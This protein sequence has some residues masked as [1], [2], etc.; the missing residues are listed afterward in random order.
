MAAAAADPALLDGASLPP[1]L[2]IFLAMF[3]AV[4]L[5][6]HLVVFRGWSPEARPEA[7]SCLISLA[8]GTP[9][10]AL[11]SFALLSDPSR[12]FAARNTGAQDAVLEYS[13]AYFLADLVH[14]LVFYPKD[15]LFIG[16]HLATLFVFLTCRY[17]VR[18]GAFAIL[19]LLILAEVTSACQNAWT[20]SGVRRRDSA[21]AAKV[22]DALSAP[23]YSFYSVVR[24]LFGPLFLYKMGVF[25]ASGGAEG[26]IPRWVWVSWLVV[27]SLAIGVSILWVS[28][29]WV[30]LFRERSKGRL[31]KKSR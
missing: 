28:N 25:Y 6:G 1:P 24:G 26:V 3:L 19:V 18:H 7:S 21:L 20:L 29:L 23:F 8:H 16:H 5:A 27:V 10:V 13:I 17:L 14:Y 31:K 2:P 30:E 15:L 11:A 9:A 22:F 12:G 4:Y